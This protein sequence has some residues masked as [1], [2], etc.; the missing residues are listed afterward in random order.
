MFQQEEAEEEA[1]CIDG[2]TPR[3]TAQHITSAPCSHTQQGHMQQ[4]CQ[5]YLLSESNVDYLDGVVVVVVVYQS[6]QQQQQ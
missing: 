6:Q 2:G 1:E 4:L 3:I 5:Q